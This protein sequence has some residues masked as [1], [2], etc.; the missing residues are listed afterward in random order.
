MKRLMAEKHPL[1]FDARDTAA[2]RKGHV[3]GARNIVGQEAGNHFSEMVTIPRD[4]LIIIYCNNPECHL[5]RML[6]EFMGAVG[7]TNLLL[8]DDGWDGWEK[9]KMP[10][11]STTVGTP[12]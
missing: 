7:F 5:G 9:A 11:D 6:A 3:K 8:Y 1:I 10:V 2:Y 12:Q 4:T